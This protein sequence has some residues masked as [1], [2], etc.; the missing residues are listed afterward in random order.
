MAQS[1]SHATDEYYE[2]QETVNLTQMLN[3]LDSALDTDLTPQ[4]TPGKLN[5]L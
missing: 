4:W 3:A 1:L 5:A 2:T